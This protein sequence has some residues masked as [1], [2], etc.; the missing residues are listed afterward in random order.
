MKKLVVKSTNRTISTGSTTQSDFNKYGHIYVTFFYDSK[1]I[2]VDVNG[3]SSPIIYNF[4]NTHNKKINQVN[5]LFI[6]KYINK[7]VNPQ[8]IKSILNINNN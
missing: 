2:G 5:A 8:E 7:C 1:K 6:E 4:N 3:F